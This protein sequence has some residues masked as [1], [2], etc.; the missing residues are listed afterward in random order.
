M[1]LSESIPCGD[2][3][4]QFAY[5][6]SM[7]GVLRTPGRR[8]PALAQGMFEALDEPLILTSPLDVPMPNGDGDMGATFPD[9]NASNAKEQRK[10]DEKLG[11]TPKAKTLPT[12]TG[13]NFPWA[14]CPQSNFAWHYGWTM[15][16]NMAATKT[17]AQWCTTSE[18]Q[19]FVQLMLDYLGGTV[20]DIV[21]G[22]GNGY[23]RC[24]IASAVWGTCAIA[25][26]ARPNQ[27]RLDG[28]KR[29]GPRLSIRGVPNNLRSAEETSTIMTTI[30]NRY[31]AGGLRG[32]QQPFTK[33]I[34]TDVNFVE[35]L[36]KLCESFVAD[37]CFLFGEGCGCDHQRVLGAMSVLS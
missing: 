23:H 9:A 29:L 7:L 34:S 6:Q 3:Q 24:T 13:S 8:G 15:G 28:H 20:V 30:Y 14:V 19:M 1:A 27:S 11:A 25:M 22:E 2:Q 5:N 10:G 37:V 16:G 21:T 36:V 18:F 17:I 12:S 33:D 35:F 32:Q 4:N 26:T 31:A